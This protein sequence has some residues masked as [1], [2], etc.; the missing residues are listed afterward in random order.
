MSDGEDDAPAVLRL[1]SP[2]CSTWED[3]GL[4]EATQALEVALAR[5]LMCSPN[6][7]SCLEMPRIGEAARADVCLY[8]AEEEENDSRTCA[9]L[10]AELASLGL[11]GM[12]LTDV[13]DDSPLA[14]LRGANVTLLMDDDLSVGTDGS[15]DAYTQAV[16]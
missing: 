14:A 2:C 6:R 16:S 13:A 1:A 12:L 4:A 11:A 9:Q 3:T 7:V 5:A 10:A 15:H 8:A